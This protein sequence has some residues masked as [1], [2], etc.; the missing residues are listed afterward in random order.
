VV[1]IITPRRWTNWR[2]F[3]TDAEKFDLHDF[4]KAYCARRGVATQFIDEETLTDVQ[5]CRI[6]WWLSLAIYVKSFRTPFVLKA[7]TGDTAYVGFGTSIDRHGPDGRK[8]VLGCSHIF[9][10]QG[11]GLQYRLSKVENPIFDGRRR[12]AFLSRDDARR[13]GESIRQLFFDARSTLPRRVVIHKRAEFRRDERDGLLE[14]LAGVDEVDM[15]EI[16]LDTA[17]RYVNSKLVSGQVQVDKFPVARGT[18]IPIDDNGAL[19]WVHGSGAAIR[20]N[21]RYYQGKRRIPAPL[22]IRRHAG[23]TDLQTLATEV[24]GLSKMNWNSFDLYTQAP[25]TIETSGQIARIGRLMDAYGEASYDYRLL[26]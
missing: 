21:W 14:G 22:L 7:V 4:V 13:V 5:T 18:V 6:R 24:L 3:E 20:N 17:F 23:T 9:N 12:N 2:C 8:V 19:L 1:L 26:M 16:Q 10:E 11:Q 25:A 15:I